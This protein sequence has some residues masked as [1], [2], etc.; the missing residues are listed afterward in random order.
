[1]KLRTK[2]TCDPEEYTAAERSVFSN[3]TNL[4]VSILYALLAVL[5]FL[6]VLLVIIVSFSSESSVTQIGYS[7]FPKSFSLEAWKY[8]FRSGTYLI[9][10]IANSFLLQ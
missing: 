9:R 10:A 2:K 7:F 3:R 8:L 5:V 4:I 1:M 6:P